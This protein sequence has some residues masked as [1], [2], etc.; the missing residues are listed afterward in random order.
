MALPSASDGVLSRVLGDAPQFVC[1]LDADGAVVLLRGRH[2]EATSRTVDDLAVGAEE[3]RKALGGEAA[4]GL[5]E[6]DG[7]LYDVWAEPTD[8]G[9]VVV[10]SDLTGASIV[11]RRWRALVRDSAEMLAVVG[12][13]GTVEY[14][15]PAV[16]RLLGWALGTE[17]ATNVLDVVHSD[18]IGAVRADAKRLLAGEVSRTTMTVRVGTAADGWRHIEVVVTN[19][20]DDPTL[21]GLVLNM[22]DVSERVLAEHELR[23]RARQQ[24]LVAGLGH[25]ALMGVD[26]GAIMHDAVSMVA[27][28]LDVELCD[29]LELV[30]DGSQLLMRA[31]VGWEDGAVGSVRQPADTDTHAGYALE[32]GVPVVAEHLSRDVRFTSTEVLRRHG[33]VSALFVAVQG[34]ERTFGVLGVHATAHRVFSPD[35]IHF[36]EAVANVLAAAAERRQVEEEIRMQSVH[37]A[38]TGLPNRTLFLDRLKQALARAERTHR[39]VAVLFLDLDR[40]KVVND[41]LG[42]VAGDRLLVE[43]AHRLSGIVRPGDTVA[44]FGGDEFVVLCDDVGAVRDAVDVA[45]RIGDVL[46]RPFSIG[47]REV[48]AGASVGIALAQAGKHEGAEALV[49][50]ADAAMY[51]AK[52]RGKGRY[53]VFDDV[54]RDRAVRRLET[55]QA[56]RQAIARHELRL[57]Y[58]PGVSLTT[59]NIAAVEALVRWE[60]PE[61]GL[62]G[63]DEF[64]PVAEETGLIVPLGEWV[65]EQA[66]ALAARLQW[67]AA[68]GGAMT[69][70]VNLS[71]RQLTAPG[72]V[73]RVAGVLRDHDL[74]ARALSLEIT[75]SVLMDDAEAARRMLV[76]LKDV[77]VYLAIDDFGTGYSSLAY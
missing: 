71:A 53:E 34:A 19:L 57:E 77:G 37:D 69:V 55:E 76:T 47:G 75:E 8:E 3:A 42:H 40:F 72:L 56:L 73:D 33:V 67:A 63:P 18:D 25:R 39:T 68:D 10:V 66:A 38:L 35:D 65:L 36:V 22:R 44:R 20:L 64:I 6:A 30:P 11:E 49:R 12:G 17:V 28:A 23:R 74:P 51:R 27:D 15:S 14:A 61:R 48:I 43:V 2:V 46:T 9:A 29:L 32:T 50:D 59:G 4:G 70:A 58:Q 21:R 24:Q 45:D 31:G 5:V 60:H 26:V 52:E 13:D 41:G 16:K 62:I 54:I 7:R 1:V